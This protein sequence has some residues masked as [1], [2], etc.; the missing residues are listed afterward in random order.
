VAINPNAG[1]PQRRADTHAHTTRTVNPRWWT[2]EYGSAWD[3]V[4]EALARDWEQTKS[5]FGRDTARDLNQ[6]VPDT[7]K[8]AAGTQNIPPRNVPNFEDVEPAYRYGFGAR[9]QYGKEFTTWDDRLE[10]R[11]RTEWDELKYGR[12]FD[13][14][15]PYIRRGW[16]YNKI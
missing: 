15:R 2:P 8:Q 13:E 7:L 9:R 1:N 14:S 5:D 4:K 6:D 3:R 12:S 10:S 11:L 16:D